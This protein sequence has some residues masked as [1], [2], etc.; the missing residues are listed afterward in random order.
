[1]QIPKVWLSGN[2]SA[3]RM[4][5]QTAASRLPLSRRTNRD[6]LPLVSG[7]ARECRRPWVLISGQETAIGHKRETG[8]I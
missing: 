6:S 2:E 5:P 3:G 7:R 8:M 4:Y 1:V